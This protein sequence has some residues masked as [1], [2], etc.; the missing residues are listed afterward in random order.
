MGSSTPRGWPEGTSTGTI[1]SSSHSPTSFSIVDEAAHSTELEILVP[2][3]RAQRALL[4][5][6]PEQT[7]ALFTGRKY[8]RIS[9]A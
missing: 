7:G 9:D 5:G 1:S 8:T 3:V 2:L 4:I 6:D